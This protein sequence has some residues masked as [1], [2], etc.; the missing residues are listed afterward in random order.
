M[1]KN[2]IILNGI[3]WIEIDKEGYLK[4]PLKYNEAAIYI[5]MGKLSKDN[6]SYYVGSSIKLNCRVISHRTLSVKWE[7]KEYQKIGSPIFYRS[8]L[9]YGWDKF[10]FGVLEYLDFSK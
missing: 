5:Y 6:V 8:T 1:K 7:R 3:D 4:K 9:K 2:K 10:K